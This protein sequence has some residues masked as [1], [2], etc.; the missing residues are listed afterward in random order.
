MEYWKCLLL[1]HNLGITH[2]GENICKGIIATLLNILGKT[3]DETASCLDLVEIGV[4]EELVPQVGDRRTYIL[5][6]YYNL[7]KEENIECVR[8][9]HWSKFQMT[10]FQIYAIWFLWKI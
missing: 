8:F 9:R 7:R 3:K 10:I 6:A 1:W 4:R 5:V 2:I